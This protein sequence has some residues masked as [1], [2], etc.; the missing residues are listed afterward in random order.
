MI[1]PKKREITTM[2]RCENDNCGGVCFAD[3]LEQSNWKC[4]YCGKQIDASTE[5]RI[6]I[7]KD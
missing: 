1:E 5:R 3:E 2:I 4:P 7:S 6:D